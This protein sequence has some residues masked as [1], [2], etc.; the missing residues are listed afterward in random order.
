VV[1]D[2]GEDIVD[3]ICFNDLIIQVDIFEQPS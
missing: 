3:P 2:G 1:S